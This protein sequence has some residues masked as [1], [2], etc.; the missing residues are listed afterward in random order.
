MAAQGGVK[1]LNSLDLGAYQDIKGSLKV[2]NCGE[3]FEASSGP[4]NK[5]W[6]S[7]VLEV[8]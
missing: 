6:S 3:G 1:L 4:L 8:L 7:R 2:S 5:F